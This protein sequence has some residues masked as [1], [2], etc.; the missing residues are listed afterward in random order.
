[1]AS[2]KCSNDPDSFCY[3]CGHFTFA[4][5][6]M[7]IDDNVK[8]FYRNYFN[9]S[10]SNQDK[11]WAPH[12][13]CKSC[14][15]SLRRWNNAKSDVTPM[16]FKTP[17]IWREAASHDECYFCLTNTFG[18]NVKNSHN[19]KYPD[20]ASVTKPIPYT[21]DD[22]PPTPPLLKQEVED[23]TGCDFIEDNKS[24]YI[25]STSERTPILFDQAALNDLVKDLGLRKDKSELLA[26]RLQERHLLASGTTFSWYRNREKSLVG[27]YSEGDNYVFCNDV[28]GFMQKLGLLY[29][30]DQW[31]LFIDSSKIS[32]KAVLLHNSNK[33]AS[34]PIAHSVYL[35]ESYENVKTI[36]KRL[37]M[38][39]INGKYMAI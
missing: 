38:K 16:P 3:I 1:M 22:S 13:A 19:I 35:K 37:N 17:V 39:N 29:D 28:N 4:K 30:T 23:N 27:Y 15:E 21:S 20:V 34:I 26:S 24:Q 33:Y 18:F 25:A 2:R 10:I 5:N 7:K 12:M 8:S 36:L 32:L 14:V 9:I 6:R 31:R 11:S